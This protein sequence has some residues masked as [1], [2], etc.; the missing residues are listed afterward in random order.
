M[1][2][3]R[4][5]LAMACCL[6]LS[7]CGIYNGTK[8][9]LTEM[10]GEPPVKAISLLA[11]PPANGGYPIAVDVV[12][13]YDEVAWEVLPEL[14]AGEWFATRVDQKSRY[15]NQIDI[16]SW[17]LVPGQAVKDVALPPRLRAA[18]GA[19]VYA[20][21]VEFD[22]SGAHRAVIQKR[23]RVQVYLQEQGFE[24]RDVNAWGEPS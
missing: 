22:D 2:L 18:L 3:E 19:V 9:T 20:D 6:T 4:L 17:E 7:A 10:L 1:R 21:Y 12:F 23:S 16:L 24:V 8:A 11:E 13:V 5:M 15:A 14:R